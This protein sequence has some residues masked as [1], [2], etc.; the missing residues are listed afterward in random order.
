MSAQ[1]KWP[2]YE[3]Q[4]ADI[5]F[6][7][8]KLY[9]RP[10]ILEAREI[11]KVVPGADGER[12][13]LQRV[14]LKLRHHEI[15]G[16]VGGHVDSQRMLVRILAGHDFPTA[17]K[18]LHDGKPTYG[19]T[20][21]RGILDQDFEADASLT[22]RGNVVA[23]LEAMGHAHSHA[24]HVGR[25]LVNLVGLK[26]FGD[27]FPY[28]I[29]AP[30]RQRLALAQALATDTR[31]IMMVD[32][33]TT[34][35]ELVRGQWERDLLHVWRR[36]Q[37]TLL[38][39]AMELDCAVFLADRLLVLRDDGS[40]IETVEVPLPRPRSRDHWSHPRFAAT[41]RHLEALV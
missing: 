32:P 7:F 41:L 8:R 35:P 18:V 26:K 29:A 12:V 40:M 16:I 5:A 13:L 25:Q 34:L 31:T 22:V 2:A 20:P 24:D 3:D 37:I 33:F 21:D 11:D 15:V 14:D 1:V 6:H 28:E 19:P 30:M 38:F 9:E 39:S 27:A 4:P 17:G 36:Q 10:V 23:T